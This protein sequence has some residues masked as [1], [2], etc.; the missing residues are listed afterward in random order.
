MTTLR[1]KVRNLP[2]YRFARRSV[3][4]RLRR[5]ATIRQLVRR[6]FD[7]DAT[8]S[9]PMDVNAGVLLEGI[10]TEALPVV[11]VV[12]I[13][14]SPD[15]VTQVIDEVARLQLV[16]A[17]FRPVIVMDTPSLAAARRYGYVVELLVPENL[18]PHDS[19]E[20]WV[21]YVRRRIALLFSTYRAT[22]S[23]GVGPGGLST[24]ARLI[25]SSL[26]SASGDTPRH[27]KG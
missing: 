20:L 7:V 6:V 27:L 2:G 8:R 17:G 26:R 12:I 18:W 24:A 25:L 11:L 9:P 4:P 5:N 21:D 10:G 13:D 1:G 23:V 19:D 16:G 3:L 15:D 14:A 22:A